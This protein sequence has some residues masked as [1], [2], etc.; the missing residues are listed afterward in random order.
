[1]KQI[2]QVLLRGKKTLPHALHAVKTRMDK[3]PRLCWQILCV[4]YALG[5]HDLLISICRLLKHAVLQSPGDI[6]VMFVELLEHEFCEQDVTMALAAYGKSRQTI[7]EC[8]ILQADII[9]F[10]VPQAKMGHIAY[11]VRCP[12]CGKIMTFDLLCDVITDEKLTCIACFAILSLDRSSL[13]HAARQSLLKFVSTLRTDIDK[14]HAKIDSLLAAA[15]LL[16]GFLDIF[17]VRLRVERVGHFLFNTALFL[18]HLQRDNRLGRALIFAFPNSIQLISNTYLLQFWAQL[19]EFGPWVEHVFSICQDSQAL[20]ELTLDLLNPPSHLV[21]DPNG[22]LCQYHLPLRFTEEENKK[23]SLALSSMGIP[24][25]AKYVCVLGRDDKYLKKHLPY[26]KINRFGYHDFRNVKIE[27]YLK[28][29]QWLCSH[30]FYCLRMGHLVNQPIE[31]HDPR[32]IE[33]ATYY[34]TPF[35]DIYLSSNCEFYIS[36]GS[37]P[38]IMPLIMNKPLLLVNFPTYLSWQIFST[39]QLILAYKKAY[40]HRSGRYL[41]LEELLQRGL[42]NITRTQELAEAGIT[43][44][45]NT[46]EELLAIVEEMASR[47]AGTWIESEEDVRAQ[48]RFKEIICRYSPP[49]RII[50]AKISVA[51][52]RMNPFFLQQEP[53]LAHSTNN[54]DFYPF[55]W[56]FAAIAGLKRSDRPP[57]GTTRRGSFSLWGIGCFLSKVKS[58][59]NCLLKKSTS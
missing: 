18:A 21:Y 30:G 58:C 17:F 36:C 41:S 15:L 48:R 7:T 55:L 46:P 19:I 34:R 20:Q 2:S 12:A 25:G 10:I 16:R 5:C 52:L 32:I 45:E 29:M 22:V 26:S 1:M 14:E 39:E 47:Y 53:P 38:D 4:A 23:A 42:G 8:A 59:V 43:L 28:S 31:A 49:G 44:E 9:R 50:R 13:R 35:L 57:L 24:V 37:G 56:K 40:C 6:P 33:Y 54:A 27:N 11:T 51:F 3:E